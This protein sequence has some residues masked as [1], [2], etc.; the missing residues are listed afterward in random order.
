MASGTVAGDAPKQRD[1]G[2]T[3]GIWASRASREMSRDAGS[4]KGLFAPLIRA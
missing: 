1:E 3:G 4:L 2:A